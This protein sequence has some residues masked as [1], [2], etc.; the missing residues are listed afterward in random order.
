MSDITYIFPMK[1][2]AKKIH[3]KKTGHILEQIQTILQINDAE[4][5]FLLEA[6]PRTIARWVEDGPPEHYAPLIKWQQLIE[7]A[8]QTLNE[9]S[10]G[11][12]FHEPNRALGGSIPLRLAAD[13]RGFCIVQD[14]LGNAAHG[15]PL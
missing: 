7:L 5:A 2:P 9:N 11:E 10:V 4:M 6:N 14:L 12:W 8:K 3:Q 1:S 15:N 13:P